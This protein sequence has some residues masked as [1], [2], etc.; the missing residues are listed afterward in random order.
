MIEFSIHMPSVLIGFF[1]GYV[2][3][4]TVFLMIGFGD[5]WHTAFST[6]WDCGKKYAEDRAKEKREKENMND[7]DI[8]RSVE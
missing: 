8:K 6:G 5:R 2:V 4:A 3:L 1:M 7:T